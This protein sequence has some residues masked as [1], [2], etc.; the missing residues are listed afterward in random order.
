MRKGIRNG[1]RKIRT[2]AMM[3]KE[4]RMG[5]RKRVTNGKIMRN[6]MR[7]RL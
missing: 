5:M 6:I 7:K 4:M 3:N 2:R 1:V